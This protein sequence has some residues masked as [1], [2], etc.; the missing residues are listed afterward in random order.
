[1]N[2]K[3]LP[4][5]VKLNLLKKEL[6]EIALEKDQAGYNSRYFYVSLAEMQRIIVPLE[7][8][9]ALTSEYTESVKEFND[10]TRVFAQRDLFDSITGDFVTKTIIDITSIKI[11]RDTFELREAI[12]NID[13]PKDAINKLLYDFF[14]PQQAGAIST[15]FQRYTYNQLYDFQE[16]LEDSIEVKGRLERESKKREDEE[17][18]LNDTSKKGKGTKTPKEERL[19]DQKAAKIRT[20][21]R[22]DFEKDHIIAT[23]DGRKL[24]EMNEKEALKLYEELTK[25]AIKT[26]EHEE[27]EL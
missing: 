1:M 3:L 7:E 16:T 22:T 13:F 6:R 4:S 19:E 18:E 21:I 11:A 15:Y 24:N 17:D 14:E 20:Q 12:L 25:T 9:Y 10:G 27:D 8:K 26:T 2:L 5:R 23:L